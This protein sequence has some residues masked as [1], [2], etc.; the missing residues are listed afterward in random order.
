MAKLPG[1]STPP[2]PARLGRRGHWSVAQQRVWTCPHLTLPSSSF[3]FNPHSLCSRDRSPPFMA[4][5]TT[6]PWLLTP[7]ANTGTQQP[8]RQERHPPFRKEPPHLPSAGNR[9]EPSSSLPGL[10]PGGQEVVTSPAPP[11]SCLWQ[12]SQELRWAV[13]EDAQPRA[14]WEVSHPRERVQWSRNERS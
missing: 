3:L 5:D 11:N 6:P 8:P 10:F 9:V 2:R 13:R 1:T 7:S 12:S 4:A 14:P